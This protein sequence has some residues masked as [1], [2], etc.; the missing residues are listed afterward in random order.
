MKTSLDK[1]SQTPHGLA[2][3]TRDATSQQSL[4]AALLIGVLMLGFLFPLSFWQGQGGFFEKIDASQHIAGWQF[5]A[6]DSWRFPLLHTT[7]INSP[8]GVNI[9]FMDSIPLAA[10]LFKPFVAWLPA[11]FHYIA[12]WHILAFI[13]QAIAAGVL[14]RSL[15]AR[16]IF[17]TVVAAVFACLWPALMW[18]FGH[19]ALMTQCL[20]LFGLA[21]YFQKRRETMEVSRAQTYLL[22][23]SLLGLLIHPYF[24]AMLYSLFLFSLIEEGLLHRR[25]AS[26][27]KLLMI[28]VALIALI[29]F[30]M[31]YGGQNTTSFGFGEYSMNLS[32]PFCGSH[33]Y[34]CAASESAHQFAAYHFA[35]PTTGQYEGLNYLGFGVF[36]L[37]P[38]SL[39]LARGQVLVLSRQYRWF[40]LFLL[41]LTFYALANRVYWNDHLL[42]EY[43]VPES[44]R[45]ITD[46]FRSS[47]RF[48]W[49][50]AYTL[51]FISLAGVMQT[52][53]KARL[54]L[55]LFALGLQFVDTRDFSERLTRIAGEPSKGDL[56]AWQ[57]VMQQVQDLHVYPAFSCDPTNEQMVWFFQRLAAQYQ[58]RIDTGYIA[59]DKVDCQKNRAYFDQNFD[60]NALYVMP[61][62]SLMN[63]PKGFVD[64]VAQQACV[65]WQTFLVCGAAQTRASL[66]DQNLGIVFQGKL[67]E[68]HWS[69]KEL[70][71]QVGQLSDVLSSTG[72]AGVLNY[73][74]YVRLEQGSYEFEFEY[75]A[76]L[77]TTAE[78]ATWDVWVT[79]PATKDGGL[80]LAQGQ[81]FGNGNVKQSLRVPMMISA[82]T[83]NQLIEFRS[84]FNGQGKIIIHA[85]HLRKLD[86]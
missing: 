31:G 38:V 34:S 51:L 64:A 49:I 19:T 1:L 60:P 22:A 40:I 81:L 61:T 43:T 27:A 23:L 72:K 47:G 4:M 82:D 53:S 41:A 21:V 66:M 68:L 79:L 55:V 52:V 50:V 5:Y 37:L 44:L 65:K 86:K 12:L 58:K 35:D 16:S 9:A 69:G 62:K 6:Q 14:M 36:L 76:D 29:F 8:D 84:F 20:L 39:Y 7:R 10:L 2:W 78:Q 80:R 83:A 73:G 18:R 24:F 59:R 33:F 32:S 26:G 25:W 17:A 70:P 30:V 74:P 56:V 57:P 3:L 42:F 85:L 46:S 15:G 71:T 75:Q 28:S 77:A 13:G 67:H 48:F 11:D 45:K 63:A 54:A